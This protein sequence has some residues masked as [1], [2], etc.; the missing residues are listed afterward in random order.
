M[1]SASREIPLRILNQDSG[2]RMDG[3]SSGLGHVVP[4]ASPFPWSSGEIRR[5]IQSGG[6]IHGPQ[7]VFLQ[8][9]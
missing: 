2:T 9:R 5:G 3:V 4:G 7:A 6:G 8:N 1:D